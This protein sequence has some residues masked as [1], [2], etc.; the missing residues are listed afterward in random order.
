M[1]K[2]ADSTLL[3]EARA[4]I[5]ELEKKLKAETSVKESYFKRMNA[6]VAEIDSV[7]TALDAMGVPR[8]V[9]ADGHSSCY[10]EKI[11]LSARLFAWVAGARL[12]PEEPSR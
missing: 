3:R 11:L 7:H 12:A 8:H 1:T 9:H 2:K 6:A 10:G 5:A 4:E